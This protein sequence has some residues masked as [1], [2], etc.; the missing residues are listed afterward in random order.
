MFDK[1]FDYW[2]PSVWTTHYTRHQTNPTIYTTWVCLTICF[3]SMAKWPHDFLFFGLWNGSI[4][5]HQWLFDAN[6]SFIYPLQEI[7]II[8]Y[9]KLLVE[10]L[11]MYLQI[12]LEFGTNFPPLM[13][14]IPRLRT[15]YV[16]RYVY[17][18]HMQPVYLS[19]RF[20]Q[21]KEVN[22]KFHPNIFFIRLKRPGHKK[23]I[24]VMWIRYFF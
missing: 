21:I 22:K 6:N 12:S 13:F 19:C 17:S 20:F 18:H 10:S 2:F 3:L 14:P 4:F 8:S 11:L 7:T 1:E 24:M 9:I 15:L 23:Y 16:V 5:D